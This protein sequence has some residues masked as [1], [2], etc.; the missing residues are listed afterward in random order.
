MREKIMEEKKGFFK[1]IFYNRDMT[2]LWVGQIFEHLADAI[3]WIALIEHSSKIFSNTAFGTSILMFWL[4]APILFLGNLV[5]VYLDR[6]SRKNTLIV[7][8]AIRVAIAGCFYLIVTRSMSPILFYATIFL[9]STVTQFFIPAKSALIPDI[10]PKENLLQANSLSTSTSWLVMLIGF[11]C[12]SILVAKLSLN[13]TFFIVMS[14]YALSAIFM[15]FIEVQEHGESVE[16]VDRE[17]HFWREFVEG[18]KLIVNTPAVSFVSR[19]IIISMAMVG[20]LFVEFVVFANTVLTSNGTTMKGIMAFG[21]IVAT[22][23][24][25][26]FLGPVVLHAIKK[27]VCKMTLIRYN[28]IIFGIGEVILAFTSSLT[29]VLIVTPFMGMAFS[30]IAILSDTLLQVETPAHVLGRVFGTVNTLRQV[31]FTGSAVIIGILDNLLSEKVS[32]F[33]FSWVQ[34]VFLTAGFLVVIYGVVTVILAF[35]KQREKFC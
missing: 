27:E 34:T 8:N 29:V 30:I 33:N 3:L 18:I 22:S 7:V 19:K 17:K 20:I 15:F 26:V 25:G 1:S 16:K 11:T 32:L 24:F 2:I 10:V 35:L 5:G 14:F 31:S 23:G 28:F 4:M 9:L 12:G 6:H 21:Y 13:S